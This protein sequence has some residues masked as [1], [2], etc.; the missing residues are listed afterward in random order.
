M[1]AFALWDRQ[2]QKL[3]LVRDRLGIKPLYYGHV[4]QD[5]VFGSELKALREYSGFQGEIDRDALA[6]F[7][8]FSYVP[9]PHCIFA[10]FK[11]LRPGCILTL[12]TRQQD[13]S[14]EA[15]WNAED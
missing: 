6:L 5:F 3:F 2:E 12:R 11:K 9:S 7:M 1:F 15:F 14:E 4:G 13:F 8:R 10:G